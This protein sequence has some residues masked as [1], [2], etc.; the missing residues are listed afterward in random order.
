MDKLFTLLELQRRAQ[1]A[2]DR[3]A[4]IHVVVN[5]THKLIPYKQAVFWDADGQPEAVS[6]NAALDARGPYALKIAAQLSPIPDSV[7]VLMHEGAHTVIIPLRT[8][9]DG[10]LG[11]LWLERDSA[12]K[13]AEQEI[14]QEIAAGYAQGLALITLRDG[15]GWAQLPG[16]MRRHHKALIVVMLALA[17]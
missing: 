1:D 16:M 10:V 8:T 6:G 4:F 9:R 15:R 13:P 14:L 7:T 11:G 12:F 17:L 2:A 3:A 5:E